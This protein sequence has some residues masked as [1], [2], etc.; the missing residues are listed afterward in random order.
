MMRLIMFA[1]YSGAYISCSY[2]GP[3]RFDSKN[4]FIE[5]REK[6]LGEVFDLKLKT[7]TFDDRY[8]DATGIGFDANP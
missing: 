3:I 7:M 2:N 1:V 5:H 8:F 6:G 4:N